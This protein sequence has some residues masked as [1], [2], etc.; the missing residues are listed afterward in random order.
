MKMDTSPPPSKKH[1]RKQFP[2]RRVEEEV[3]DPFA[4]LQAKIKSGQGGTSLRLAFRRFK[5]TLSTSKGGEGV[6]FKGFV[7]ALENLGIKLSE[8]N[9]RKVFDRI[10]ENKSGMID[11]KEFRNALFPQENMVRETKDWKLIRNRERTKLVD[12]YKDNANIIRAPSTLYSVLRNMFIGKKKNALDGFR[13]FMKQSGSADTLISAQEVKTAA[14]LNGF[15][16]QSGVVERL[17]DHLDLDGDGQITVTE[18]AKVFF[19]SDLSVKKDLNAISRVRRK[20][21]QRTPVIQPKV[22][23]SLRAPVAPNSQ[24]KKAIAKLH[25]SQLR[26]HFVNHKSSSYNVGKHKDGV[27]LRGLQEALVAAGVSA[28]AQAL[29]SLFYEVD[30]ANRGFVTCRQIAR[31]VG[32]PIGNAATKHRKKSRKLPK[33]PKMVV[34][35]QA[36]ERSAKR[37]SKDKRR[38]LPKPFLAAPAFQKRGFSDSMHAAFRNERRREILAESRKRVWE[39]I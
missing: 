28:D 14:R 6:R 31:A 3:S 12:L 26:T 18:F 34:A 24:L 5:S 39:M 11:Y 25:Y 23:F 13:A 32:I 22:P 1:T 2:S 15:K 4:H 21:R 19:D 27:D 33:F 29:K 36:A 7:K 10:D 35:R 38:R 30:V 8:A 17:F 37:H 16:V 20:P 9:A